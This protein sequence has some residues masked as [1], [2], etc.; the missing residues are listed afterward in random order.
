MIDKR[1]DIV[2]NILKDKLFADNTSVKSRSSKAIIKNSNIGFSIDITGLVL[3]EAESVR[4]RIIDQIKA[5]QIFDK[6]NIVLTS[7]SNSQPQSKKEKPKLHIK[8]VKQVLLI[9]SGKGGVGKSTITALV[10]YMLKSMGKKV[11]IV[12][13]DIYGPSIPNIFAL[14]GKPELENDRMIPLANYGIA[15]NSIGFLIKPNSSVSWRGPMASKALYQLL[16]LTDWGELDYLIIDS[17]PG[18]GDIHLSILENYIVNQVLMVTTP[19]KISKIDVSRAINLYQKFDIPITGI[20]ENMSYY[21][22]PINNEKISIF[23]GN[24]GVALSQSFNLPLITTIPMNPQLS[25]ACDKGENLEKFCHL[26][27]KVHAFL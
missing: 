17:P 8:G 10:A 24:S 23:S 2:D 12:D 14:Q 22:N 6:I 19:Q 9:A 20:I 5:L 25:K 18:T 1:Q 16:S 26:V 27:H 7:S 4:M 15:I 11:G 3:A 21:I 13:A